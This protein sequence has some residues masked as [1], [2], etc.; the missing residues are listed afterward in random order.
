MK[1]FGEKNMKWLL[2]RIHKGESNAEEVQFAIDWCNE[3]MEDIEAKNI[4]EEEKI[5]VKNY[6]RKTINIL[7]LTLEGLKAKAS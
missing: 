1:E 2:N 5:I 7:N 4:S 6:Y 3:K